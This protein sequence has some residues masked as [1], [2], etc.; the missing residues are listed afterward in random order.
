M[1]WLSRCLPW[2]PASEDYGAAGK[3]KGS[4]LVTRIHFNNGIV[5]RMVISIFAVESVEL[6]LHV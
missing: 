4:G 3:T 1:G 6:L 2:N 5:D